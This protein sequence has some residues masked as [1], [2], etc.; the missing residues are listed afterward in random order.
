[1][2]IA[3]RARCCRLCRESPEPPNLFP[4]G[5]ALRGQ[6]GPFEY[7]GRSVQLLAANQVGAGLAAADRAEGIARYQNLGRAW[8]RIVIRRLDKT[9]GA[10]APKDQEVTRIHFSNGPVVEKTVARFTYGADNVGALAWLRL[11]RSDYRSDG[12]NRIIQ[13]R[14]YEIVHRCIHHDEES[15]PSALRVKH[16]CEQDACRRNQCAAWLKQQPGRVGIRLHS[17]ANRMRNG[18]ECATVSMLAWRED[19]DKFTKMRE[20][21][22]RPTELTDSIMRGVVYTAAGWSLNALSRDDGLVADYIDVFK[23]SPDTSAL[24]KA[25]LDN[26]YANPMFTKK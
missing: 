25:E 5:T 23:S 1:V 6:P 26:L 11:A 7:R 18:T 8:P 4:H 3:P 19:Y 2:S 14:A 12:M 15:P 10:C 22:Q 20:S 13:G 16:P 24:V 21:G 17:I 9:I